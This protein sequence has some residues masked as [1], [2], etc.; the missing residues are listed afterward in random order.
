[1]QLKPINITIVYDGNYFNNVNSYYSIEHHKRCRIGFDGIA[2]FVT[3]IVALINQVPINYCK[4]IESH[5]FR[6]R[7]FTED[8]SSSERAVNERRHEDIFVTRNIT[9]H[10]LPLSN[11]TEKGIDVLLALETYE[12]AITKKPD[13]IVLIAGDGDYIP[14]I[15]KLNG[16]GITTLLLGWNFTTSSKSTY[17]NNQLVNEVHF[18]ILMDE[19]IDNRYK[20]NGSLLDS[21]IKAVKDMGLINDLF[22]SNKQ[23]KPSI[24][25][26]VT[27]KAE[28]IQMDIPKLSY[29][30]TN[31]FEI[32]I[33]RS[34]FDTSGYI[35]FGKKSVYFY[36]DQLVNI[37]MDILQPGD[38]VS[39][40]LGKNKVGIVGKEIYK[41][42]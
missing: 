23:D 17:T 10:Y 28:E 5:W 8:F 12:L 24:P 3:N 6:G 14:L 20:P 19:L 4:V 32:G 30:T 13:V 33:I 16:L 22:V 39:F 27:N 26:I 38:K 35:T 41:I 40:K 7:V 11:G 2:N 15:R 21:Y 31:G 29:P 9:S 42:D 37:T 36:S 25:N 34:L 1:M 18:P